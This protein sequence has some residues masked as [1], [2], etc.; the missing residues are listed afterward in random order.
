MVHECTWISPRPTVL[1]DTWHCMGWLI[2][3]TCTYTCTLYILHV[4]NTQGWHG[5][6]CTQSNGADLVPG[7]LYHMV[8]RDY[9]GH[10]SL[11]PGGSTCPSVHLCYT[12]TM[13]HVPHTMGTFEG[14]RWTCGTGLLQ[15]RVGAILDPHVIFRVY[16]CMYIPHG[17]SDQ[18]D[19]SFLLTD[20]YVG[21]INMYN[22]PVM[23]ICVKHMYMF[24][25]KMY[26]YIE[27]PGVIVCHCELTTKTVL[28]HLSIY[29]CIVYHFI[30]TRL[31]V[32]LPFTLNWW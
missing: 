10:T 2:L 3:C 1:S 28:F 25:F 6:Y 9:M 18:W 5:V 17:R 13:R 4:C 16:T 20:L 24:V 31:S 7:R 23:Y 27:V 14:M 22:Y 29:I 26:T 12:I 32:A 15:S 11:W 8:Y 19:C 30:W 21:P